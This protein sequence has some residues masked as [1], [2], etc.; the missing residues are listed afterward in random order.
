MGA[1]PRDITMQFLSEAATISL[2]AGLAG[3]ALGVAASYIIERLTDIQT[4]VS[5]WSAVLSFAVSLI[6]GL[7]FG[8]IPARKA[9][10][11]DPVVSLR[12]E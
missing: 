5:L 12:Y 10:Q 2:F 4:I 9:S 7:V 6:V 3:V 8:F 11:Q 1:T